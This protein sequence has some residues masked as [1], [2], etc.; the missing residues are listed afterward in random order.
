MHENIAY[1]HRN[2]LDKMYIDKQFCS[3]ALPVSTI[4]IEAEFKIDLM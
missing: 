1:T 2:P 3:W 4:N